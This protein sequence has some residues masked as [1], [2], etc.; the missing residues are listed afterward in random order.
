M[1]NMDICK[2]QE[3]EIAREENYFGKLKFV[4]SDK[5]N[6]FT[7][8]LDEVT[9]VMYLLSHCSEKSGLTVMLD[10]ETGLPLTLERYKE[11]AQKRK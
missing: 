1:N 4:A 7:Y 6:Y 2:L 9:R 3:K 11:L 10:P 8:Y 5:E